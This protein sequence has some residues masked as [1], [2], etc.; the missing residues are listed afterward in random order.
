MYIQQ[1]TERFQLRSFRSPLIVFLLK[2]KSRTHIAEEVPP[3]SYT[4]STKFT[5]SCH[6]CAS[7]FLDVYRNI[8]SLPLFFSF[9][10]HPTFAVQWSFSTSF[11]CHCAAVSP[12]FS[13]DL[14]KLFCWLFSSF[15]YICVVYA[16]HSWWFVR[17]SM[18]LSAWCY[19]AI[20]P[21]SLG[22]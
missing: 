8:C 6:K 3:L 5:F 1:V 7:S 20:G 22:E 21:E 11:H 12:H 9:C 14:R 13:H 15:T 2:S 10:L 16:V 4:V 19:S 17:V 18:E